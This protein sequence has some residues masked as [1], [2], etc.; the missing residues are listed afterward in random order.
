MATAA[1]IAVAFM[2]ALSALLESTDEAPSW[3]YSRSASLAYVIF[4]LGPFLGG[5]ANLFLVNVGKVPSTMST[6]I[7]AGVAFVLFAWKPLQLLLTGK[8]GILLVWGFLLAGTCIPYILRK[9][10]DIKLKN[11]KSEILRSASGSPISPVARRAYLASLM[12]CFHAFAEG[13]ALGVAA[14]KGFGAILLLPASLHG[15]PRGVAVGSTVY[16]GMSNKKASLV[17]AAMTGVAGPIGCHFSS[18]YKIRIP[19]A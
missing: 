3:K 2:E 4:G 8:V 5:L 10:S 11:S 6:G 15:V 14:P 9:V 16:G 18:S 7:G 1:T 19:M 12:I 13:L 17:A